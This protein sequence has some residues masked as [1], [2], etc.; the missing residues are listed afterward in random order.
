MDKTAAI[1]AARR[2]DGKFGTQAHAVANRSLDNAMREEETAL[3]IDRVRSAYP[4][5]NFLTFDLWN[6]TDDDPGEPDVLH[7]RRAYSIK[8]SIAMQAPGDKTLR[9]LIEDSLSEGHRRD[10][11]ERGDD[12][13]DLDDVRLTLALTDN[14]AVS[15]WNAHSNGDYISI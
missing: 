14:P 5:A 8:G 2:S 12:G 10:L 15:K 11:F 4:E 13:S 1:E 6:E 7:V 3:L 9:Y